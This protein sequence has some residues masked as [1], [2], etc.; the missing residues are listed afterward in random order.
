MVE[1]KFT[2]GTWVFS[3][4]ILD[5]FYHVDNNNLCLHSV[6]SNRSNISKNMDGTKKCVERNSHD[7][8]VNVLG[9][10]VFDLEMILKPLAKNG[11]KAT[12]LF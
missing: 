1:G 7:I 6:S 9:S 8:E 5:T 2:T 4:S 12:C 3:N 10:C 11:A